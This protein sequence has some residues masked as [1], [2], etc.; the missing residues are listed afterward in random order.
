MTLRYGKIGNNFRIH[1]LLRVLQSFSIISANAQGSASM[2]SSTECI[3]V[4]VRVWMC[5]CA[6]MFFS[7]SWQWMLSCTPSAEEVEKPEQ[8]LPSECRSTAVIKE[9][10]ALLWIPAYAVFSAALYCCSAL[11]TELSLFSRLPLS[12][13]L[14]ALF[15][16]AVMLS[17]L[18]CWPHQD[19]FFP[20][21]KGMHISSL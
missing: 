6:H 18:N 15:K 13:R 21:I 12:L 3:W 2:G 14:C 20:R 9:L 16:S 1:Y 19:S 11:F 7:D 5:M 17:R 10:Q 4:C 8:L